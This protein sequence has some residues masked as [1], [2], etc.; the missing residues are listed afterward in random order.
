M[1]SSVTTNPPSV[2]LDADLFVAAFWNKNSASAHVLQACL[3][4]RVHLYYTQQ[5]RKEIFLAIRNIGA[6]EQY[7]H[8]VDRI[9]SDGTEVVSPGSRSSMPSGPESDKLLECAQTAQADYLVTNDD[10]IL[11]L[12]SLGSTVI[13]KASE[14]RKLLSSLNKS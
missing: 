4:G 8:Q 13:I 11:R 12:Q 10:Y 1:Y 3:A 2:V 5:M 6:T 7:R 9:L 14:F